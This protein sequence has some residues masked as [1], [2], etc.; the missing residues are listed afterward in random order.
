MTALQQRYL[1][2][3]HGHQPSD[4]HHPQA[5]LLVIVQVYGN[6]AM[7][8]RV[9][10]YQSNPEFFQLVESQIGGLIPLYG[11]ANRFTNYTIGIAKIVEIA[12]PRLNLPGALGYKVRFTDFQEDL[13]LTEAFQN[14]GSFLQ[15]LRSEVD[16]EEILTCEHVLGRNLQGRNA[17]VI[18]LS[19]DKPRVV[20]CLLILLVI[21][22]LVGPLARPGDVVPVLKYFDSKWA[23]KKPLLW[24]RPQIILHTYHLP[25]MDEYTADAFV[26]RDEPVPVLAFSGTGSPPPDPENKRSRLRESISN[27][28][29]KEKLQDGANSRSDT[30]FSLQ[31]RLL[32]K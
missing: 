26:N 12:R 31:D 1:P 21:S 24:Q 14:I 32:T 29:L 8:F 4:Y 10:L 16:T 7:L 18:R 22:P 28:K 30:G 27:S 11:F 13:S 25:D 19:L 17:I 20:W 6:P 2:R 9:P 15:H 3:E 5:G 23:R